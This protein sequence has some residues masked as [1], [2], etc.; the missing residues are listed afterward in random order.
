MRTGF[1]VAFVGAGIAARARTAEPDGPAHA[2][3]KRLVLA[4]EL[5]VLG[6]CRLARGRPRFDYPMGEFRR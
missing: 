2:F 5:F 6:Y 4:N 3:A 1:H